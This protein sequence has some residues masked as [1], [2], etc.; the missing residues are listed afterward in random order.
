MEEKS[1]IV[2]YDLKQ[3]VK[4]IAIAPNKE[5]VIVGGRESKEKWE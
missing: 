5:A 1:K 4:A 2:G 3:E